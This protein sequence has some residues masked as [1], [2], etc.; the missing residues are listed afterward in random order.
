M[1]AHA[2]AL[3][4]ASSRYR[5]A[6]TA[7]R[8]AARD[9]AA[10]AG[11]KGHSATEAGQ[12]QGVLSFV[13]ADGGELDQAVAAAVGPHVLPS[14]LPVSLHA[15]HR[16]GAPPGDGIVA[17]EGNGE[18]GREGGN[19]VRETAGGHRQAEDSG[20]HGSR[21]SPHAG[22]GHEAGERENERH[23]VPHA[24]RAA[25]PAAQ[26]QEEEDREP[27]SAGG[28]RCSRFGECSRGT[29]RE[30][31]RAAAHAHDRQ[32]PLEQSRL[33]ILEEEEE[34]V[35][36]AGE[37]ADGVHAVRW[38]PLRA[39][40]AKQAA[41]QAAQAGAVKDVAVE[42]EDYYEMYVAPE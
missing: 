23:A 30:H 21:Q 11:R 27:R 31:S 25:A 15:S 9:A 22:H 42:G 4:P 20:E 37:A 35:D 1:A 40:A 38:Q 28:G 36:D 16:E 29:G 32:V 39:L 5:R 2:M 33:L 34:G 3:E 41:R 6:Y 8:D 18:H 14:S 13:W 24:A 19:P 12:D 17:Q 10:G 26:W 7:A